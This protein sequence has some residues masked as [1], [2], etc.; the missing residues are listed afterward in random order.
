VGTVAYAVSVA[1]SLGYTM[2]YVY[3]VIN[4]KKGGALHLTGLVHF[5]LFGYQTIDFALWYVVIESDLLYDSLGLLLSW[6]GNL[7]TFSAVLINAKIT[8]NLLQKR[9]GGYRSLRW[10]IYILVTLAHLSLCLPTYLYTSKWDKS[11]RLFLKQWSRESTIIWMLGFIA[12]DSI[13][14][15]YT[16][17]EMVRLCDNNDRMSWS[18]VL[19]KAVQDQLFL[20]ITFGQL[21]V[22]GL[23]WTNH[24]VRSR[25]LLYGSEYGVYGG[26]AIS[27]FLIT[28]HAL[29]VTHT[30]N[31]YSVLVKRVL[32]NRSKQK[33]KLEM[34]S[35]SETKRG[36]TLQ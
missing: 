23:Y 15:I 24:Y 4:S 18:D 3:R 28:V 35:I 14:G 8:C 31:H 2:L 11:F 33:H 10:F 13:V 9:F 30:Y 27:Q 21:S 20:T 29:L 34:E 17:L 6:T 25:T 32:V 12:F 7:A 1:A 26:I 36:L 16:A 22:F 5:F 19:V